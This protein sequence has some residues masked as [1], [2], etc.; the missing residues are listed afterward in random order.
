[1][2]VIRVKKDANYTTMSNYHL[3]DKTLSLKAKGLLSMFLSLPKDWTYS[4]RGLVAISKEGADGIL[5]GLKELEAAG[6]LERHRLR[7]EHGRLGDSE[8]SIF[9][10]PMLRQS[11]LDT[12]SPNQDIPNQAKPNQVK[13]SQGKP[14]QLSIE[15]SRIDSKNI[16]HINNGR[17]RDF[18]TAFGKYKNVFLSRGDLY[19]LQQEY[20]HD[21]QDRIERL[22]E[23]MASTGKV[24][25]NHLATIRSWARRDGYSQSLYDYQGN[26][27]L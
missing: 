5:S 24:Y 15:L 11:Y 13:P 4:V 14:S 27:S 8:Y 9:E 12:D 18:P 1:M 21:Y 19:A 26:D 22:S 20:P 16:D 25:G 10:T 17:D 6:Y 23:Y 7:D 2:P 3:R